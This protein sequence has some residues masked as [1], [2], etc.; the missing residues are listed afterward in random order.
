MFAECTCRR[1]YETCCRLADEGIVPT[2]DRLM[3]E[4]D[5]PA[6]K[7]LLVES[8]RAAQA[9]GQAVG[10]SRGIV[11]R[12][13]RNHERKEVERQRPAQIGALR[14]GGLDDQ[15]QAAMLE[16]IIRQRRARAFEPRQ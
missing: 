9:T 7:S 3:L 16:D 6:M 15:Q 8:T 4:F 13:G 5:E 11:E 14:E 10:R 1:I 2:F 12:T